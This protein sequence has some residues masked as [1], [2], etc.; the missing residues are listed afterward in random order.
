MFVGRMECGTSA[1]G[2][3]VGSLHCLRERIH[4]LGGAS[5][6]NWCRDDA[7]LGILAGCW[8]CQTGASLV[9]QLAQSGD[10]D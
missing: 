2:R 4:N 5:R 8:G 10:L 1:P 3:H 6:D 9:P 7:G